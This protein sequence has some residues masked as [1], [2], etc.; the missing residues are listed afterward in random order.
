MNR[1]TRDSPA[2]PGP[3]GKMGVSSVK[4]SARPEE[5]PFHRNRIWNGAR[6]VV[7][8]LPLT[9]LLMSAG[10]SRIVN[11]NGS[12]HLPPGTAA[13]LYGRSKRTLAREYGTPAPVKCANYDWYRYTKDRIVVMVRFR[14]NNT[15]DRVVVTDLRAD[16][17]SEGD[18]QSYPPL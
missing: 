1:I 13:K 15:A 4:N 17:G 12:Y 6:F 5:R 11:A 8:A 7:L 10:A 14:D 18:S 3:G 16:P 9:M 2:E